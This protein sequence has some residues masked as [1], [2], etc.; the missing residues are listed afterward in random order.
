MNCEETRE[1]LEQWFD[2]DAGL[3]GECE[4]HV[5]RCDS[6]RSY[7][8]ELAAVR[9]ALGRLPVEASAPGLAGRVKTHVAVHGQIGE[10]RIPV[11]AG[12]ALA[13]GVVV[14]ASVAGWFFPVSVDLGA[15]WNATV[16]DVLEQ[17]PSLPASMDA[18]RDIAVAYVPELDWG[19]AASSL[20][21][22]LEALSG[23]VTPWIGEV[24][25][26]FPSGMLWIGVVFGAMLLIGCNG[27]EA[28]RLRTPPVNGSKQ[29][30]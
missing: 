9:D 2:E 16:A 27:F 28:L 8:D 10:A 5:A 25:G 15:W 18:W 1:Q 20:S 22:Q 26:R 12:W 4:A 17:L 3:S 21:S 24:T 23:S 19:Q 13:A 11:V 7:R 14:A 30:S 6:C 29:A